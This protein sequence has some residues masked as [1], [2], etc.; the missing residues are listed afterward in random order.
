MPVPTLNMCD[1]HYSGAVVYR[2]QRITDNNADVVLAFLWNTLL[3]AGWTQ[4][5]TIS[6]KWFLYVTSVPPGSTLDGMGL[7]IA[8]SLGVSYDGHVP[9]GSYNIL[10][11]SAPFDGFNGNLYHGSNASGIAPS[12]GYHGAYPPGN[13]H[14]VNCGVELQSQAANGKSQYKVRLLRGG[15]IM[16][17]ASSVLG[18][19]D[20]SGGL[21]TSSPYSAFPGDRQSHGQSE[22]GIAVVNFVDKFGGTVTYEVSPGW[23][24]QYGGSVYPKANKVKMIANP[25]Q[26]FFWCEGYALG[27]FGSGMASLF[28]SAPFVDNAAISYLVVTHCGWMFDASEYPSPPNYP[29]IHFEVPGA[30]QS[31]SWLNGYAVALND[32]FKVLPASMSNSW[33]TDAYRACGIVGL[34]LGG[35]YPV[36]SMNG[37]AI[38]STPYLLAPPSDPVAGG[39]EAVIVGI[40]WDTVYLSKH[41]GTMYGAGSPNDTSPFLPDSSYEQDSTFMGRSWKMIE[42]DVASGFANRP[43]QSLWMAVS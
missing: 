35:G 5:A 28:A 16:P 33:Y 6:S 8:S 1:L 7:A 15:P 13:I 27:P 10:K 34:A 23:S 40:P 41:Y 18:I 9:S 37:S 29:F 38:A 3:A 31:P 42:T 12:W 26:F 20:Y 14:F 43:E 21:Y 39:P 32:G 30:R 25:Y 22:Y 4:T 24:P 19:P 2:E 17:Q 36:Y 11:F